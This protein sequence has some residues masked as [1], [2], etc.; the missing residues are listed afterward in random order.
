MALGTEDDILICDPEG[1]FSALVGALGGEV[2]RIAVG[3]GAYITP[4]S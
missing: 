3:S 1:E 4:W 2:A